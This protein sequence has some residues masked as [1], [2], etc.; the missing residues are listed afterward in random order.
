LQRANRLMSLL[1]FS[2]RTCRRSGGR[3]ERTFESSLKFNESKD[4]GRGIENDNSMDSNGESQAS[5]AYVDDS[6]LMLQ[7]KTREK[8][9]RS[10]RAVY[11]AK[12]F[13]PKAG[14]E[15]ES[16]GKSLSAPQLCLP[17]SS[18]RFQRVE[19]ENMCRYF[20]IP[21]SVIHYSLRG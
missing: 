6:R 11:S 15:S 10:L 12:I 1:I 7:S 8:T 2:L 20:P 5:S 4:T 18:R 14:A 19:E 3:T 17:S 21:Y 13:E 16:K 9:F